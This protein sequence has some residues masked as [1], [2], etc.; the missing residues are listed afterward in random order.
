VEVEPLSFDEARQLASLLLQET[1]G[2]SGAAARVAR[3]SGGNPYFV[4]ELVRQAESNGADKGS[5][6]PVL[7]LDEALWHRVQGLSPH[8]RHLLEVV[9]VA[10]KPMPLRIACEAA[11]LGRQ[12]SA[13]MATLHAE[14]LI[15]GTGPGFD[16]VVETYHDRIRE[17]VSNHVGQAARVEHHRR[18]GLAL[19]A[20]SS[21][22][23]EATA[24]HFH[25]AGLLDKAG[26][27]YAVAADKA[28]AALAF[29]RSADLYGL[30]LGLGGFPEESARHLRRR[31]GD[32]LA[33]AGRGYEAGQEYQRAAEGALERQVIELQRKAGYQYF[34]SGHID[35]GRQA[36]ERVLARFGKR[37]PHTRRQALMS[38]LLRRIWLRLRGMGFHERREADVPPDEL[39]RVD[40]FWSV[41][42]GMTIADPI[43]GAEYQTYDLIL[44]LRA[45]EP[46]RIARALAWE[47]AHISMIGVRLK[48]RADEELAAAEALAAR[49]DQPHASGMVRMSR[50]V[51]AYFHGDFAGCRA[52]CEHAERIF[53]DRCRGASRELETCN[54]FAFWTLYFRG[55]YA[56]LTR[57]FSTL[58][59]EIR[60][61]GARLAEADLTTFG[62][63]FVWLAADDPDGA[64][65]AVSSVMGEWS[66]QDFQVQHFTTL[67]A[68]A[69]IDLYRGDGRAAWE[70]VTS[71]WAGVAD[72]MLLHVEIVRIYMLHLRARC[73]LAAVGSGLDPELLLKSA[74][75]DARRLARER[76]PYARALARTIHAA[77]AAA[78]GERDAAVGLLGSAADELDR[79]S[80]GSFGTGARR[81]YGELLGGAAGRRVV[82]DV[83]DYLA[84][85][86]VKRPDLM[87]ALQAPGFRIE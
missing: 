10:G 17:S 84:G 42:A 9:A 29:D 80:W 49:I 16:D 50:G 14:R 37:L 8:A 40:I 63:P 2:D 32:A 72:A 4:Y 55:E 83:D 68:E 27:H 59:S 18:L 38:L 20:A 30:A 79:L 45:G 41:A 26:Q 15:R 22:D 31:R 1:L 21:T 44:A 12:A 81:R 62:G 5:A 43:R 47:A 76:P 51:A 25:R 77:L 35:E 34:V 54:A 56:D 6:T 61:R 24:S 70:R 53:R 60:L 86:G 19:E 7:D 28:A 87:A 73:A 66:R 74:A 58:I 36:F 39:E 85:Q 57:R 67:T 71:H 52:E 11:E 13:A 48:P 33:N 3:E 64:A 78:R 69:Q 23:V 75:R 46:Y 82:Q 65:R